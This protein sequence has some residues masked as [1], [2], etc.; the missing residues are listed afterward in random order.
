MAIKEI[1]LFH[2]AVLMKLLRGDRPVS[3]K[4]F[5]F[6]ADPSRAAYWVNDEVCLYV[7][8][9]K[10]PQERQRKGFECVWHFQ[11]NTSHLKEMES[12]REEFEVYA[13]LVCG[14][15]NV[16]NGSDMFICFLTPENLAACIDLDA[17]ETQSITV[18]NKKRSKLR[19]WGNKNTAYDPLL[20]DKGAMDKWDV[21]GQ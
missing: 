21:P 17:T 3:L 12:L 16:S 9:S 11:F 14:D 2:G 15:E 1:E 13:V 19:V 5:E 20:V 4:L 6:K 18:A 10:T 7:K 8:H